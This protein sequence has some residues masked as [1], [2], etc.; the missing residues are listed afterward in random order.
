MDRE[1]EEWVLIN[2]LGGKCAGMR[3]VNKHHMSLH[4]YTHMKT[5]TRRTRPGISLEPSQKRE[6]DIKWKGGGGLAT[7]EQ[8]AKHLSL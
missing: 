6:M 2:S 3:L 5:D 8:H 7:E 4:I 1:R